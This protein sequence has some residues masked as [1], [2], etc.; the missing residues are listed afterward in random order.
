MEAE[1]IK[2]DPPK[3]KRRWFQFSLRTLLIGVTLL[4]AVCGYIGR[5]YEIVRARK[6][7]AEAQRDFVT[8]TS[9]QV[10]IPWIRKLLGDDG[11]WKIGLD[12]ETDKTDASVRR[13][14]SQR[15]RF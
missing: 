2:T 6:L 4:A 11:I 14:C 13:L 3:R 12:P 5:Q 10:E 7:F 1:P 15:L 9:V 8:D